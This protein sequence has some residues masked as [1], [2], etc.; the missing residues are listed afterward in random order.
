MSDATGNTSWL[1]AITKLYTAR[2]Q[3]KLARARVKAN[4][5][6]APVQSAA[7]QAQTSSIPASVVQNP[8]LRQIRDVTPAFATSG[9]V[10]A[11][12]LAIGAIFLLPKLKG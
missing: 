5:V 3:G 12:A 10:I 7:V 1:D 6:N 2:E 9:L 11:V 8:F 4:A